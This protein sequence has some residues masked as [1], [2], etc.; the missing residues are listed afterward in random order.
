MVQKN[1]ATT[2]SCN[3]TCLFRKDYSYVV[4]GKCLEC[5]FCYNK[6]DGL[7]RKHRSSA[8]FDIE[9]DWNDSALK[10]PVTVS[11][12]CDPLHSNTSIKNSIYVIKKILENN[13]QV[14]FRT[15]MHVIPEELYEL[16]T[17]YK[18]NFMFQGRIFSMDTSLSMAL[19]KTFAPGFSEFKDMINTTI[20]FKEI[21]VETSIFM[22]PFI[23]GIND[24]Y[25]NDILDSLAANDIS[26]ITIRQLFATDFFKSAL[27]QFIPRYS[28]LLCQKI[29]DYWT[30]SNSD[31]IYSI[32]L[33]DEY[34][35]RNNYNIRFSICNNSE[36]RDMC[37][38]S[39]CCLFDNANAVY[40]SSG[41]PKTP[42]V[43]ELK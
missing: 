17:T 1:Y 29:G 10:V 30:Y 4:N 25:I 24:G 43:K 41:N 18:D 3:H 28:N 40:E 9:L 8:L 27:M 11:R 26:K 20:R 42:K 32:L 16:A 14:I 21:G 19:C 37:G 5:K 31:L 39:N 23:I 6:V 2:S 7:N 35:K 12:Y 13:G 15:A 33:I 36:I 22:D 34:I 38:E